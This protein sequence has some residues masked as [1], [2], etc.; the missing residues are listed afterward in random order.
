MQ[1]LFG[2]GLRERRGEKRLARIGM[3][4]MA[5]P[6]HRFPNATLLDVLHDTFDTASPLHDPDLITLACFDKPQGA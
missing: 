3:V 4:K 1:R 2:D 6:H 5:D